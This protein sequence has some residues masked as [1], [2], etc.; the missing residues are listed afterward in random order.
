ME[1]THARVSS[2][3]HP[4]LLTMFDAEYL[5][6]INHYSLKDHWFQEWILQCWLSHT[7]IWPIRWYEGLGI[8]VKVM[9]QWHFICHYHSTTK[10]WQAG[11]GQSDL[12]SYSLKSWRRSTMYTS[13]DPLWSPMWHRECSS[14]IVT[15]CCNFKAGEPG[16]ARWR[17]PP[18]GSTY[19]VSPHKP[20][21]CHC[22][23]IIVPP[24]ILSRHPYYHPS[25]PPSA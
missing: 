8:K 19:D 7:F 15:S 25:W 12:A 9:H 11:W 23:T 22:I 2:D 5:Y 20:T 16:P 17:A 18:L 24:I 14:P 10:L 13:Q 3:C 1:N 21:L 6:H 4:S